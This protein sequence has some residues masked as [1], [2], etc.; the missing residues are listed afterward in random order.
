[1][2]TQTYAHTQHTQ[3]YAHTQ[4]THMHTHTHTHKLLANIPYEHRCKNPQQTTSK[5]NLTA[6]EKDH[7]P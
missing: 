5:L 7:T 6:H 2:H 3:T 4:H 1:M